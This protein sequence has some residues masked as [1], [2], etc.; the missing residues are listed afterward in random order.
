[1]IPFSCYFIHFSTLLYV[2]FSNISTQHYLYLLMYLTNN[3]EDTLCFPVTYGFECGP[4][5]IIL[6]TT[7]V[8]LCISIGTLIHC[9]AVAVY[10]QRHGLFMSLFYMADGYFI[11]KPMDIFIVSQIISEL[12]QIF[13]YTIALANWPRSIVINY[14][15]NATS[16]AIIPL[17]GFWELI[18]I[19]SH[20]PPVFVY[21]PSVTRSTF[22]GQYRELDDTAIIPCAKIYSIFVP[23]IRTLYWLNIFFSILSTVPT[24]GLSVWSGWVQE[25]HKIDMVSSSETSYLVS[26]GLVN[27]IYTSG[28]IYYYY[29]F[30][31]ILKACTEQSSDNHRNYE[32][33]REMASGFR[34]IFLAIIVAGITV[35]FFTIAGHLFSKLEHEHEWCHIISIV[36]QYAIIY[37]T[38]Q[39]IISYYVLKNS[40]T[41]VKRQKHISLSVV[42]KDAA[43]YISACR[44]DI[45]GNS[46]N[47]GS[48]RVYSCLEQTDGSLV[49]HSFVTHSLL[50][51]DDVAITR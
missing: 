46:C 47:F 42:E 30:Y 3:S 12:M 21:Q 16:A 27:T 9:T 7:I 40:K 24:I 8:C 26:Y 34:N 51:S 32:E 4:R 37:P 23:S 38:I 20:I 33:K 41:Q 36:I 2:A 31:R 48:T 50:A 6:Y 45:Y 43:N 15:I 19:V 39:W 29:G 11:P 1:M 14:I 35:W 44:S 25:N 49:W 18:G 17:T 10:R 22:Q 28:G 13:Q 5:S